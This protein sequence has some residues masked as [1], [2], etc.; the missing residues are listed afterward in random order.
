DAGFETIFF[1]LGSAPGVRDFFSSAGFETGT[2]RAAY[3][4]F[5]GY[6]DYLHEST[7]LAKEFR[8]CGIS[9]VHCGDVPAGAHAALGGRLAM[10][11]VIC[12]VR[13]RHSNIADHDRRMLRAVSTFAFVSR[14]SWRSF[15]YPVPPHRGVVV[16]DGVE[17]ASNADCENERVA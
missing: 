9:L 14:D 15:G 1:C 10:V 6:R 17:V 5:N 7:E 12:H 13:N 3:P 4:K 8:R 11:P 2:W 16:Y